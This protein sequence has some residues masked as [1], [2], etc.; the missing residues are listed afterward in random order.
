[1]HPEVTQAFA[2]SGIS[3]WVVAVN[4]MSNT[5]RIIAQITEA[6]YVPSAANKLGA[7]SDS[8]SLL[9]RYRVLSSVSQREC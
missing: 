5:T 9:S 7:L 8:G 1:M 2:A 3:A 4:S 6:W